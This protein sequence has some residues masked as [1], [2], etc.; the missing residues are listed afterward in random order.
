MNREARRLGLK[1][2]VYRIPYGDGGDET[3]RTTT[4]RE[5]GMLAREA[6][7]DERFRKLVGTREYECQVRT[8][9]GETRTAKWVNTNRLL[10]KAG[11]DGVKTG[12][13][14]QAGSCLVSSG[15]KGKDHLIVVVLGSK[16]D[17]DRYSDTEALFAW[18]WGE[19]AGGKPR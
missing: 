4:P 13:T 5:L 8:P 7:K 6:L 17:A 16:A 9:G 18:A 10:G 12:T 3:A 2:T 11:Y 14:N 19:R 15:R 1:R